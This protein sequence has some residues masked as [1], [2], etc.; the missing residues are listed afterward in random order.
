MAPM[1]SGCVRRF[2]ILQ[3]DYG[4]GSRSEATGDDDALEPTTKADL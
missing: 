1:R 4:N 2:S 3:Q